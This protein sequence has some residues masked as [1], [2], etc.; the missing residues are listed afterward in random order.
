MDYGAAEDIPEDAYSLKQYEDLKA[1][2]L[3]QILK[4]KY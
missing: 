3:N 4:L 2:N 1:S